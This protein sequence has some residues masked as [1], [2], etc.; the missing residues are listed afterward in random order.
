MILAMAENLFTL[1]LWAVTHKNRQ[2]K[3]CIGQKHFR[4]SLSS[5]ENC[6]TILS[7]FGLP[8]KKLLTSPPAYW[9]IVTAI[10]KSCGGTSAEGGCRPQLFHIQTPSTQ[11]HRQ[12]GWDVRV[13][14]AQQSHKQ[15][16]CLLQHDTPLPTFLSLC[17]S[18][19]CVS[20]QRITI[21]TLAPP[22]PPHPLY[23]PITTHTFPF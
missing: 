7:R 17:K 14:G 12:G 23:P 13:R 9:W 22:P 2:I 18:F 16:Q 15:G 11:T 1:R 3:I 21:H 19:H 5:C 8:A 6:Q 4:N 10:T 20:I